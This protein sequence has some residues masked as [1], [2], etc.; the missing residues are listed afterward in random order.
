MDISFTRFLLQH[1]YRFC[2]SC[3][4]LLPELC[5]FGG[6]PEAVWGEGGGSIFAVSRYNQD[7]RGRVG[8]RAETCEEEDEGVGVVVWVLLVDQDIE[9]AEID[10]D[11]VYRGDRYLG[12]C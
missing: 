11:D 9:D 3:I 8:L 12:V 2:C 4:E 6:G 10:N 1:S 5:K 7:F